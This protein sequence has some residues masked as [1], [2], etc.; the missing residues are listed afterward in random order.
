MK[1]EKGKTFLRSFDKTSFF[2]RNISGK[3]IRVNWS[4][5]SKKPIIVHGEGFILGP[6]AFMEGFY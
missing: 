1:Y 6:D 5:K 2:I 4:L 3:V